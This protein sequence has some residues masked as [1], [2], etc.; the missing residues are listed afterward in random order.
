VNH[1]GNS[2]LDRDNQ[3]LALKKRVDTSRV[4]HPEVYLAIKKQILI[5]FKYSVLVEL[6]RPVNVSEIPS[7]KAGT[8]LLE[9]YNLLKHAVY[10]TKAKPDISEYL[11][12]F[13]DDFLSKLVGCEYDDAILDCLSTKN[14]TTLK[15]LERW[16]GQLNR[17]MT[18]LERNEPTSSYCWRFVKRC[19][20]GI[21]NYSFVNFGK[22]TFGYVGEKAGSV[23]GDHP[24]VKNSFKFGGEILGGLLGAVATYYFGWLAEVQSIIFGNL[25][26]KA[27]NLTHSIDDGNAQVVSYIPKQLSLNLPK[28]LWLIG[29]TVYL[30]EWSHVI[31]FSW[32]ASTSFGAVETMRRVLKWQN[33]D[34]NRYP[35]VYQAASSGGYLLG[36]ST[37]K[38]ARFLRDKSRVSHEMSSAQQR[39]IDYFSYKCDA[40]KGKSNITVSTTRDSS[41]RWG[42]WDKAHLTD[43]HFVCL[44]PNEKKLSVQCSLIPVHSSSEFSEPIF[45]CDEEEISHRESSEAPFQMRLGMPA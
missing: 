42:F 7:I 33:R 27:W 36:S 29:K 12:H 19:G 22:L 44:K 8:E 5:C 20:S 4:T 45:V 28:I 37:Y 11:D 13:S 43:I 35:M 14:L 16:E 9:K 31:K 38:I 39:Y 17:K 41:N 6:C 1:Y 26:Y 30:K 15:N 10:Q 23:F 18:A 32:A 25:G 40:V 21:W 3:L 34:I 2:E 24:I